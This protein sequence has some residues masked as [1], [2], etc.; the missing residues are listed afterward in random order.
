MAVRELLWQYRNQADLFT[1][2]AAQLESS[3]GDAEGRHVLN[4]LA[5]RSLHEVYLWAIHRFHRE[6]EPPSAG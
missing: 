1:T 4:D 3:R 6:H 2:A 5:D